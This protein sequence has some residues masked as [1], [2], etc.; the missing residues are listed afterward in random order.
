M[1]NEAI[2]TKTE[3]HRLIQYLDFFEGPADTFYREVNGYTCESETMLAF[4]K[5]LYDTGFLIVFDWGAWLR[6]HEIYKNI[7][8]DLEEQLMN[9]DME[10]LRKLVTSYVR[11]DRFMEGLFIAVAKNGKIA[12]VL[13]RLQ[14]FAYGGT[15]E[16]E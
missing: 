12:Q 15:E 2:I 5:E 7:D 1:P 14:Q 4:R 3:I 13:T 8:G 16:V 9:A 11:G 10:T 6:E